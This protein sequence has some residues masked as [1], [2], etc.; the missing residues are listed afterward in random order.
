MI[1]QDLSEN[2]ILNVNRKE[3]TPLQAAALP[4]D[5]PINIPGDIAS[6][7]F[8]ANLIPDPYYGRNELEC[9][10]LG[11]TD[12]I[13]STRFQSEV[14]DYAELIIDIIDTVSE[15]RLNGKTIGKSRNMFRQVVMDTIGALRTGE[16]ILEIMIFSRCLMLK[17]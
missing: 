7:L 2:W 4:V 12:W 1:T 17:I 11:R 8:M 3:G 10:W 5:I 9:L 15:V 6:A 16:N 14:S 13:L